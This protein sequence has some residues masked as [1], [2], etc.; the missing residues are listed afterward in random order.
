[1]KIKKW[2]CL[3]AALSLCFGTAAADGEDGG[4][5]MAG[6]AFGANGPSVMP[7]SWTTQENGEM[8]TV[9]LQDGSGATWTLDGALSDAKGA[10]FIPGSS[11]EDTGRSYYI[12]MIIAGII[13]I[14]MIIACICMAVAT[15]RNRKRQQTRR[16]R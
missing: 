16:G 7:V 6:E 8:P 13:V 10:G 3:L 9:T 14:A 12:G 1:M 15:G 11:S 4:A 2:I 5:W